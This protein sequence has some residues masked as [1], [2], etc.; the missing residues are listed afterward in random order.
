MPVTRKVITK[1]GKS[2][3]KQ[4][5]KS[6]VFCDW[7]SIYQVHLGGVPLVN[8]GHVFSVDQDGEIKWDVAAKLVHRGSHDTS[9]RIRSDGF[10]VSLE[11]NIGRFNRE[12]NLF[13]YSVLECV[14][15]AN[16]LLATFG[17]PAF[18][19]AAPMPIVK[20][21]E[22][23]ARG[24]SFVNAGAYG[25]TKNEDVG[26]LTNGRAKA[27]FS[28]SE[29]AG[30]QAVGAVITRVDLTRNWA[31]GSAENCS[32]VIRHLQGFKSGRQEP[33][34]YKTTGVA[35]GEGSKFWY[36]KV[37]DKAAEYM[38]QC[39]KGS[40]KF[41]QALFDFMLSQG[42]ARHEVELKSRYLKQ[43]NLWRMT[44]WGDGMEDRVYAL[45]SDVVVGNAE[46]DSYLEIPGRA[47]ELAVAWRDGADLK[48]RLAQN[49]FYRYRRELLGY[50]IDIAVPCN[51]TRLRQR[52]EVISMTPAPVP[53]W[54]DLPKVA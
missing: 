25:N 53:D 30:Y 7:I 44:R 43:H 13:G 41:N 29:D 14:E 34:A 26:G 18:F 49:T 28:T 54:Y 4:T 20:R 46:V 35:W 36:A 47:G 10:R 40:R 42:I 52:V 5:T 51:V 37:Y 23:A 31:T 2:V 6:D 9:V 19:D 39:G 48:K 1:F 45:F 33:R 22:S 38:R 8:D 27:F 17:L 12:D 3:M 24:V 50:G 16:K 21:T 11:G 32:Q 15:L